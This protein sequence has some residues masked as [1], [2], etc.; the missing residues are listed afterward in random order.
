MRYSLLSFLSETFP[1][2]AQSIGVDGL[3]IVEQ[4]APDTGR[5]GEV[6][7]GTTKGFDH[8]PIVVLNLL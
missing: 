6:G 7:Q 8:D 4:V 5:G 2:E 1:N 3:G